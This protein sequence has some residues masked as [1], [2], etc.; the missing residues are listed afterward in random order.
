M[1][2]HPS[3]APGVSLAGSTGIRWRILGLIFLASFVAYLLRTNMSVAGE[4]MMGELGLTQVQLGVVLAAFAWGYAAFQFPGGVWGERIGAR[5]AIFLAAIAWG[6]CNLAIGLVPG[7][8]KA[9]LAITMGIL[10]VLRAL[11]GVTQAPFYPV[12]GGALTCNWF[13]V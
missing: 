2:A 7:A 1:S 12:T 11:M 13:P 4:R 9:P 5:R 8:G 6:A 10:I 3:D